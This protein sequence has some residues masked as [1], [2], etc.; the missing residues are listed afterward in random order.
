MVS[1][2]KRPSASE[3]RAESVALQS[4]HGNIGVIESRSLIVR[5]A[6][7]PAGLSFARPMSPS[8]LS[9]WRG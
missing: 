1:L 4:Q 8:V 3:T 5:G 6:P 9:P 7:V 2:M